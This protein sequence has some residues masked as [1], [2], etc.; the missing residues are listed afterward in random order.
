MISKRIQDTPAALVEAGQVH[1][2]FFKT[3]FRRCNLLDAPCLGGAAG[4]PLRWLRLKEWNGFGICHP[5]LYGAA[6]MQNAKYAASGSVYLY[7]RETHRLFEWTII[8]L[9]TRLTLPP[10][11]WRGESRC[12]RGNRTMHFEHHLD[13]GWHRV[14]VDIAESS[15][16]PALLMDLVLHQDWRAI[17]PLVASLPIPPTHHTY[18]HK[19]PLHLEGRVHIGGRYYEYDPSRDRG[20]LDEQKTFYP[21]RSHWWWGSFTGWS[22]QGREIAVNLVNQ[23]TPAG[24]PGEDALWVDGRL[25]L[26][27]QPRFTA[28]SSP[29]A[30]RVEDETGQVRLRFKADGAKKEQRAYGPIAMDY[31]QY[32]GHYSGE[33]SGDDGRAHEIA[34]VYGVLEQMNARF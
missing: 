8:D 11:L 2:G 20:A 1:S 12:G 34:E 5:K 3:P 33:V 28:L 24:E 13:Y 4:R 7:E 29:G 30:F 32:F 17:D 21:Y 15:R 16:A 27:P 22:K 31:R 26:I 6:I 25:T 18:T 19:S 9:P 23:M 14:R 10:T